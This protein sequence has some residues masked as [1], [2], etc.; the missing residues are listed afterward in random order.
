MSEPSL[1][2]QLLD[3][4]GAP[5]INLKEI[6]NEINGEFSQ[7][8]TTD[9]R[10]AL[11]QIFKTIMDIVEA[12]TTPEDLEAFKESRLKLYRTYLVQEATVEENASAEMLGAITQREIAAGRMAP[13]DEFSKLAEV[14]MSALADPPPAAGWRRLIAW[15]RDR[16]D[17]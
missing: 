7:S 3:A 16:P 9:Q 2:Q 1:L 13:D 17:R 5:L 6:I 14:G 8:P 4:R 11:L 12:K 15:L 10:V